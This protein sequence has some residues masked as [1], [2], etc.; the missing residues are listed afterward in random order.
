MAGKPAQGLPREHDGDQREATMAPTTHKRLAEKI[1]Y[2]KNFIDVERVFEGRK[3]REEWKHHMQW[4]RLASVLGTPPEARTPGWAERLTAEERG[5]V[6]SVV[7]KRL[8]GRALYREQL[9]AL[10]QHMELDRFLGGEQAAADALGDGTSMETFFRLL[11]AAGWLDP[12]A[13]ERTDFGSAEALVAAFSRVARVRPSGLSIGPDT[14]MSAPKLGVRRGIELAPADEAAMVSCR[15]EELIRIRVDVDLAVGE[16]RT[17]LLLDVA[18]SAAPPGYTVT[19]LA[20]SSAVPESGLTRRTTVLPAPG[21]PSFKIGA[22]TG[23]HDLIAVLLL[24]PLTLPWPTG[25]ASLPRLAPTQVAAL[26]RS[27]RTAAQET[28]DDPE[29]IHLRYLVKL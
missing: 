3:T 14:V 9:V 25:E 23:P 15:V 21:R 27:L 28:T 24:W 29:V 26:L 11:E 1:R 7:S 6:Q 12:S 17:L 8:S 19:C 16:R 2:L 13:L 10:A 4:V 18:P 20:P 5:N 22:T